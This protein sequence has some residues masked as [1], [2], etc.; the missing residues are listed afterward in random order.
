MTDIQTTRVIELWKAVI[1]QGL[2][3]GDYEA[4]AALPVDLFMA[5]GMNDPYATEDEL[6]GHVMAPGCSR[7]EAII[8]D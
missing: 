1:E 5:L 7:S 3:D 8:Y 6:E 2:K 4:L